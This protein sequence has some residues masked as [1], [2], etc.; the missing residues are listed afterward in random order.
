[1]TDRI[2]AIRKLLENDPD[3]VFL[4]YS[5]AMECV[6]AERSDEALAAF[7]ACRELDPNYVPAYVEAGKCARAAGQ[8]DAARGLF[9]EGLK[10]AQAA[11]DG[12]VADY[13]TQQ[14]E[15]LG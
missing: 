6:A 4:H 7:E 10:L 2:D 15:S 13:L 14:L 11:A 5:L 8:I 9:Q 1:M 12:H 3:D